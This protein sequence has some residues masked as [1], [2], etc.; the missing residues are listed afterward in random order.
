MSD[1]PTFDL[2]EPADRRSGPVEERSGVPLDATAPFARHVSVAIDAA[3]GG[4]ARGYTYIVPPHLADLVAGEAV[5]VEFGR[6]QALGVVLGDASPP[7]GIVAKAIV[8]RVRADGP[9]LPPLALALARWIAEHY[10]APPAL[11]LRAMLPPGF[12]E[13]LELLAERT[14]VTSPVDLPP[15]DADLLDQLARGPR[16]V[17]DLVT[18]E[19]RPGLLRR[20]RSLADIGLVSLDWTLLAAGAGPR[21]E[22]RIRLTAAG[23][24]VAAAVEA[25]RRPPGRALGPRQIAVQAA[26]P[27]DGVAREQHGAEDRLLGFDVVGRDAGPRPGR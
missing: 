8:G 1:Q 10:L 17:R 6:R 20:L 18:A 3:G 16:A 2:D 19:G 13:R 4:G 5:L 27:L 25:G 7:D 11:V 14:A 15:A 9:L 26:G 12:L 21:F 22:R 24:E 23:R